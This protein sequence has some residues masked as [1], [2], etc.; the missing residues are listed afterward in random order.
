MSSSWR[1]LL[2]LTPDD[3]VSPHWMRGVGRY[4]M[5]NPWLVPHVH[6]CSSETGVSRREL[7]HLLHRGHFDGILAHAGMVSKGQRFPAGTKVVLIDDGDRPGLTFVVKDQEAAARMA[8]G[9]LLAQGLQHFA[10]VAM[11]GDDL[12]AKRR[13]NGF[14]T[15]L[16]TAG[17]EASRF[18]PFHRRQGARNVGDEM[19]QSWLR[20]L[21]KPVGIHT[22]TLAQAMRLLW[23][24]REEGLRVP[25]EVALI[26]GRD[27]PG[28]S[29]V[30]KPELSAIV[31]DEDGYENMRV[32]DELMRGRGRPG[33][34]HLVPPLHLVVR[35][36]SLVR[37]LADPEI[38]RLCQWIGDQA[39]QAMTVKDLLSQTTLSR[40]TLERRF[41]SLMGHSIHD[42][43][44]AVHLDRARTL[45]RET[46]LPL[47]Q[48][49][50]Q[51][52]YATYMAFMLTFKRIVGMTP[53]A[54]RRRVALGLPT[55]PA[56][57]V[58]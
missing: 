45:L 16:A 41:M 7:R 42:E 11:P 53:S 22:Y 43:I 44:T 17:H 8:A 58:A 39:H 57:R 51:S 24:C 1:I 47:A 48:V 6:V 9:H 2:A 38:G 25:A 49:A 52:G 26:G 15:A 37:G 3:L 35:A 33:Q 54:Y 40:R 50:R 21:P 56:T 27:A 55:Q 4:F 19:L 31:F 5:L 34:V 10:F 20:R 29:A 14:R 12:G 13:W 32:L 23:I 36:S 46:L 28:V 30:L 18:D